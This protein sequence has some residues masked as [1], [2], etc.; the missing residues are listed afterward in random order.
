[1]A[2]LPAQLLQLY[3]Y[4]SRK[5]LEDTCMCA[6]WTF[7]SSDE[8]VQNRFELHHLCRCPEYTCTCM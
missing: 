6:G 3:C 4:L 2:L 8:Q 7:Y 5:E 1:M